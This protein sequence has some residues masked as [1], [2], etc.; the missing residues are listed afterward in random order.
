MPLNLGP[1]L[2]PE[3][4]HLAGLPDRMEQLNAARVPFG[5]SYLDDCLGGLYP[6]DLLIVGAGSGV[7]KTQL[8]VQTA[9]AGVDAGLDP[10]V[11]FALEAELGEVT[12]RLAFAE[13]S[14]RVGNKQIDFAGWWRGRW[15]EETK[16]HWPEVEANLQARLSK[17]H[18]LYKRG[19]FTNRALAKQIE[20]IVNTAKMVVLDHIHVVDNGSESELS[21]QHKTVRTLRDL[22]LTAHVP[23][24]AIS[25]LRKKSQFERNISMPTMDDLHGSS[26]MQK[27]ATGVVLLARDWDSPSPDK[28]LAP[29][30]VQVTK[31]RR[32]RASPFVARVYYDTSTGR[33]QDGYRLGFMRWRD[34]KQQWEP[35]DP[36]K[37][38]YWAKR[39]TALA[40]ELPF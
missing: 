17:L 1:V 11:L 13:L 16:E 31:D 34:K 19:D 36:K 5:M 24:V 20:G 30:L 8:A 22:A 27:V 29:T 15:K 35:S 33:Y 3:A 28:H 37:L 26:S 14:E 12:A 40:K 7:G 23:V 6:D 2:E 9:L 21:T 32:G 4:K 38:P 18:T 10:V 39:D 25:H